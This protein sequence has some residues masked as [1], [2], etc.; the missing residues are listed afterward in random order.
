MKGKCWH[1]PKYTVNWAN[2]RAQQP[3]HSRLV[4]FKMKPPNLTNLIQL[5]RSDVKTCHCRTFLCD[6]AATTRRWSWRCRPALET[7]ACPRS[8]TVITQ[9]YLAVAARCCWWRWWCGRWGAMS[10][11]WNCAIRA[12]PAPHA[13]LYFLVPLSFIK[14]PWH[15][16]QTTFKPHCQCDAIT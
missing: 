15:G 11:R 14:L 2:I 1:L 16:S 4:H 7:P 12:Y 6:T 3:I 5:I 13:P 9:H 10:V 8:H